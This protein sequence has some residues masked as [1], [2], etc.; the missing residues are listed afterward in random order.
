MLNDPHPM[1]DLS[2]LLDAQADLLDAL[3]KLGNEQVDAI[4]NGRMNELLSLLARKQPHLDE[5]ASTARRL[6]PFQT[7]LQP[8]DALPTVQRSVCQEKHARATALFDE[9]FALEAR[10]EQLLSK[11]RDQIARRLEQ[12]VHS[13]DVADAYR[14]ESAPSS[15]GGRLD[16]S[17]SN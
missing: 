13:M 12:T 7:H 4:E 10:C 8:A 5:L 11:S 6:Q 14:R 16:L 15:P 1:T 3:I 2:A 9:L 17:S